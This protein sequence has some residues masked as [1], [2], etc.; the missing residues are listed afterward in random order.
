[1]ANQSPEGEENEEKENIQPS[2]P[3]EVAKQALHNSNAASADD[4]SAGESKED[5]LKDESLDEKE[6]RSE[7]V[8]ATPDSVGGKKAG[9]ISRSEADVVTKDLEG[10]CGSSLEASPEL[11]GVSGLEE[12]PE[13]IS[14]E[15]IEAE[16][17]DIVEKTDDI[18]GDKEEEQ[19]E[20][21][22]QEAEKVEQEGEEKTREIHLS[23]EQ[24]EEEEEVEKVEP[25]IEEE[26][27]DPEVIL[28]STFNF[29]FFNSD[30]IISS[31]SLYHIAISSF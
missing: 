27:E 26:K 7:V 22:V 1:M 12:E 18:G 31:N 4:T 6:S 28:I 16:K 15:N 25:E 24:I 29:F 19:E 10:C 20:E 21:E 11:M 23:E 3:L 5:D 17:V 2:G 14:E 9:D 8:G 30:Q 13:G